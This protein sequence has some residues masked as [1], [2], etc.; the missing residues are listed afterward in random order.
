MNHYSESLGQLEC[1]EL[2]PTDI[3]HL[4]ALKVWK[5]WIQEERFDDLIWLFFEEYNT[6]AGDEVLLLL[7]SALRHKS[8]YDKLKSIWRE[9]ITRRWQLL[10]S[11][12]K[13]STSKLKKIWHEL[14]EQW[15]GQRTQSF[16]ELN[17]FF[18]HQYSGEKEKASLLWAIQQYIL[19]VRRRRDY[20]ECR[21][22]ERY[23]NDLRS[24]TGISFPDC[25][26]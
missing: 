4:A 14:N 26:E 3:E 18:W 13:K 1:S 8:E 25:Y 21:W 2:H 20:S 6:G 11:K 10:V 9:V 7:S 22:L 19:I 17:V 5:N 16:G 12:N 24:M 23:I 15:E